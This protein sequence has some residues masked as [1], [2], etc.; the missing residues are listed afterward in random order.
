M[1]GCAYQ[2]G[3][4]GQNTH[5]PTMAFTM[6]HNESFQPGL[7][8]RLTN[9]TMEEFLADG[10]VPVVNNEDADLTLTG[11]I[12]NYRR[13]ILALDSNNDVS[14]YQISISVDM[15]VLNTHTL[16]TVGHYPDINMSTTY[17]PQRSSI[18][19]ETEI[20]AQKRLL[21]DLSEEIVYR[22]M[23]KDKTISNYNKYN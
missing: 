22:L 17:E 18:E 7:E 12:K 10:R 3:S 2:K 9:L 20:E 6:F 5:F 13:S 1:Y 4:I 16:G 15:N 14:L 21:E 11:R 8:E 19:F 23:D